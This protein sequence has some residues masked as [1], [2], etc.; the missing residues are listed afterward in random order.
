MLRDCN[1][2]LS[3][4]WKETTSRCTRLSSFKE[5]REDIR[6]IKT[7]ITKVLLSVTKLRENR[8]KKDAQ[9][10]QQEIGMELLNEREKT[11]DRN[12]TSMKKKLV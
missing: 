3:K 7:I 10:S 1:R 2:E 8:L 6:A 11:V 5:V 4:V 12:L 9:T